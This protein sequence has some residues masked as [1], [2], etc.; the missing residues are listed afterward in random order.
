MTR[1]LLPILLTA[2]TFSTPEEAPDTGA[3]P[4]VTTGSGPVTGGTLAQVVDE[5]IQ[6][7]G[8]E[9]D[10]L[11]VVDN[12]SGMQEE[13]VALAENIPYFLDFYLGSGLDYHIGVVSTDMADPTHSGQLRQIAGDRWLHDQTADPV[14]V[15]SQMIL[16][17]T[18]GSDEERGRDAAH[19]ALVT[20]A[21]GANAGFLRPN[22]SLSVIVLSDEDDGSSNISHIDWVAWLQGEQANRP[23]VTLNAIVEFDDGLQYIDATNAVGGVLWDI[24]GGDYDEPVE[25]IGMATSG[26]VQEFPLTEIPVLGT[27][28]V[29]VEDEGV[30]YMFASEVDW[31]YNL[32]HNAIVFTEF[33]P[34]A[35]STIRVSYAAEPPS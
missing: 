27:I 6:A 30:V 13:Q 4:L 11:F 18:N 33:V 17:G 10:V 23:S 16:L 14:N 15:L 12:S 29:E 1:T 21:G 8:A 22:S 19:S 25:Q 9:V 31:Q 20:L 5:F 2:C 3:V 26:L 28:A 35:L 32:D 34:S 7:P 24:D